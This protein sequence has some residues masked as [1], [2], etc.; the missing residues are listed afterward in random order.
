MALLK[1]TSVAACVLLACLAQQVRLSAGARETGAKGPRG[2][3]STETKG[4]FTTKDQLRCKWVARKAWPEVVKLRVNCES[5]PRAV[6]DSGAISA[7]SCEYTGQ[8]ASCRGYRANERNFWKQTAR[9]LKKLPGGALCADGRVLVKAGMCKRAPVEAHFKLGSYPPDTT[10]T[11]TRKNRAR[12][13]TT[14]TTTRKNR[15]RDTTTTT[16]ENHARH[17]STTAEP[18]PV[19]GNNCSG[20]RVD[21]HKLAEQHC[22]SAW[23]SVCVF[24][25]SMLDNTDEFTVETIICFR[26]QKRLEDQP[27]GDDILDLL[28]RSGSQDLHQ[29]LLRCDVIGEGQ[30][31]QSHDERLEFPAELALE[32]IDEVLRKSL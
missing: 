6:A 27:S 7:M 15:A 32:V 23:S 20:E 24:F 17:T 9:A 31:H 30:G 21:K 26:D 1:T 14:T 3:R 8:P 16:R 28:G 12:D 13:T 5:L 18:R 29:D 25:F 10:T 19:D 2:T 11:T 22:S 4:K